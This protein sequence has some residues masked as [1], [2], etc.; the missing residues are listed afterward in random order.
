MW[1]ACLTFMTLS[2][3]LIETITSRSHLPP[4]APELFASPCDD[5][6]FFLSQRRCAAMFFLSPFFFLNRRV[7]G[8]S[9]Y[10][11]AASVLFS[12]KSLQRAPTINANRG[13]FVT[14]LYTSCLGHVRVSQASGA[15]VWVVD[16]ARS[17]KINTVKTS[18]GPVLY[19]R[20]G[21]GIELICIRTFWF[22][23]DYR[24]TEIEGKFENLES[25]FLLAQCLMLVFCFDFNTLLLVII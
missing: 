24:N 22:A 10:R 1:H 21:E 15:W 6:F 9:R 12:R 7:N 4:K 16:G 19:H 8:T 25:I 5:I 3:V 2:T 17:R 13:H 23:S 14:R 11:R 20:V 18:P